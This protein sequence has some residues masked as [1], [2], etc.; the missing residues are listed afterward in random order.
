VR[1]IGLS[2]RGFSKS[3]QKEE[4]KKKNDNTKVFRLD[5]EASL[6]AL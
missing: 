2:P 4:L 3:A 1:I 5:I 6:P